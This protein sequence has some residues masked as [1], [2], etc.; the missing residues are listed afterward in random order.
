MRRL[1]SAAATVAAAGVLA[2]AVP[3]SAQAAQGSVTIGGDLTLPVQQGV[4]WTVYQTGLVENNSN[5]ELYLYDLSGC[6]G[7]REPQTIA[8]GRDA[9]AADPDGTWSFLPVRP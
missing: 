5:Y 7:E 3:T 1:I 4:C 6:R 2:V 8:P 9:Y